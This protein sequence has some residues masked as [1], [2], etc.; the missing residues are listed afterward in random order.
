MLNRSKARTSRVLICVLAVVSLF[1]GS[2]LLAGCG[3]AEE[4][5]QKEFKEEWTKIMKEFQARLDS[6]DEKNNELSE[7]Q[8]IAGLIAL[9]K[10]RMANSEEVLESIL[11]LY[12][13]EDLRKLDVVSAYY[14][15][16]LQ[17]RL[18]Q[19]IVLYNAILD[20]TPQNEIVEVLN[21]LIA[22]NDTIGRELGIE[23]QKNGI[24]IEEIPVEEVPSTSPSSAPEG[25]TPGP[26]GE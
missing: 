11:K 17:D 6:D 19:Q 10:Q 3:N 13:P 5:K 12:P 15:I 23:M 8:D 24:T 1:L 25:T 21:N 2:F 16:T 22:R 20:D 9:T 4:S 14:L 26:P 7:N 18:E